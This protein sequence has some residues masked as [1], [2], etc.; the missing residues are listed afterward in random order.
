M[1]GAGV[2]HVCL[3]TMEVQFPAEVVWLGRFL[4]LTGERVEYTDQ[5][6]HCEH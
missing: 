6:S 1:F 5:A 4:Q 3:P 2:T